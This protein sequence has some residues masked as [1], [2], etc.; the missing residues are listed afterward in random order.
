MGNFAAKYW[1]VFVII[2]CFFVWLKQHDN[3]VKQGA[4]SDARR[5]SLV[6]AHE[7]IADLSAAFQ[8]TV[9]SLRIKDSLIE[10]EKAKLH[11]QAQSLEAVLRRASNLTD[12]ALAQIQVTE[13]ERALLTE[14]ITNERNQHEVQTQHYIAL[15]SLQ[16][17]QIIAKDST[18]R[19][20]ESELASIRKLNEGLLKEVNRLNSQVGRTGKLSQL[21]VATGA[22][23]L[24][25]AL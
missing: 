13:Q 9:D 4:L 15:V 11:K 8:T 2:I 21:A 17:Q 7:A 22:F 20:R 25:R 3:N 16:E 12:S 19:L 6:V 23:L 5:D 24:G 10:T 14:A 1:G 18:I